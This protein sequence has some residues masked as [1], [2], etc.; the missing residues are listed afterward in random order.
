M[1]RRKTRKVWEEMRR[2]RMMDKRKTERERG[3]TE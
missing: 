1:K 2:E 3:R